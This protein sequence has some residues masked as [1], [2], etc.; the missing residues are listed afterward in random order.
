MASQQQRSNP[1]PAI[2]AVDDIDTFVRD[3]ESDLAVAL[4]ISAETTRGR[5]TTY[6]Y[7]SMVKVS[8]LNL[9]DSAKKFT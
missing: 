1:R 2:A 7:Y 4:Q 8:P 5:L 6:N 9:K 3:I